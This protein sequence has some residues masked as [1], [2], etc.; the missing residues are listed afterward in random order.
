MKGLFDE[1]G[2]VIWFHDRG[3]SAAKVSELDKLVRSLAKKTND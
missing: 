2:K 3:Y 1:T